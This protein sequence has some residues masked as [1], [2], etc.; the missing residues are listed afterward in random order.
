M[1]AALAG[2]RR[3]L[4]NSAEL[5][6]PQEQDSIP[7]PMGINQQSFP[8]ASIDISYTQNQV[9]I[10]APYTDFDQKKVEVVDISGVTQAKAEF[11]EPNFQLNINHLNPGL[12]LVKVSTKGGKL[13]EFKKV[14]L[15]NK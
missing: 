11:F 14:F 5:C 10:K 12:Y 9:Q 6:R 1:E 4:L 7:D 15:T 8:M 3:K 13:K 2:P